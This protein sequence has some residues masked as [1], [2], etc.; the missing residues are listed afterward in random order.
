MGFAIA[1]KRLFSVRI[2]HGYFLNQ[3]SRDFSSLSESEQE[4]IRKSYQVQSFFRLS[5]TPE[6]EQLLRGRKMVF[7]QTQEGFFVGLEIQKPAA[8]QGFFRP[9]IRLD[10]PLRL[11]FRVDLNDPLFYNYTALPLKGNRF[12]AYYFS[13][14]AANYSGERFL[15]RP[16]PPY[17]S[18]VFYESGDLITDN[19]VSPS[20]LYEA[21][22]QTGPGPRINADWVAVSPA[23]TQYVS[24]ED[25]IS[26]LPP[27]FNL[28]L[29]SNPTGPVILKLSRPGETTPRFQQTIMATGSASVPTD[30]RKV[31]PG[32]YDLRVENS[33]GVAIESPV[34]GPCYVT[35]ASNESRPFAIVEIVHR[36]DI[37]QGEYALLTGSEQDLTSPEYVLHFKNRTTFWRYIFNREQNP[38][39]AQ[40]GELVRDGGP[41]EKKKFRT[42]KP[43]PLTRSL[44]QLKKFNTDVLLPNPETTMIKPDPNDSQI[45]SEIYINS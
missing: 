11:A 41:G 12:S 9:E 8:A 20:A 16:I 33:S 22:R 45:Y 3:G 21:I 43:F 37:N 5:P 17:R 40:L 4:P 32:R 1:Y 35:P 15:S 14:E 7:R 29:P 39:D 26:F 24:R 18:T 10:A 38:S 36:T 27:V 19:T 6:T 30:L 13:N 34:A 42:A 23:S 28:D 44:T 2:D 25:R 31:T